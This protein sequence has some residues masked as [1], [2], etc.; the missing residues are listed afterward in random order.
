MHVAALT[1]AAALASFPT[2]ELLAVLRYLQE[3]VV[4]AEVEGN[5]VI[6]K[7]ASRILYSRL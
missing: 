7:K 1:E 5:S 2:S 4:E 3:V 6:G